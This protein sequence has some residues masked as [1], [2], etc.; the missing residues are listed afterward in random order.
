MLEVVA[1]VV[2]QGMKLHSEKIRVI[3]DKVGSL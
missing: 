3:E 1:T 2:L